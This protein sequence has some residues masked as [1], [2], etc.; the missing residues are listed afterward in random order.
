MNK[1][2]KQILNCYPML[3]K[4]RNYIANLANGGS[5]CNCPAVLEIDFKNNAN[6]SDIIILSNEEHDVIMKNYLNLIF[7]AM[8]YVESNIDVYYKPNYINTYSDMI[9]F[10]FNQNIFGITGDNDETKYLYYNPNTHELGIAFPP[11]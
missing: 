10:H 6:D 9:N 2:L 4:D 3:E 11:M 7:K 5:G 8:G 1:K